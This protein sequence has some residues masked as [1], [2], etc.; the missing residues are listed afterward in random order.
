[1]VVTWIRVIV[2]D[3]M[4]VVR[5]WVYFTVKGSKIYLTDYMYIGHK[6]VSNYC[7]FLT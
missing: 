3:M 5:S 6:D 7:K 4:E 1:M 2:V